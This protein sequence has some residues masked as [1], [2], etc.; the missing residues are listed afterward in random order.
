[1]PALY[2]Q[3]KQLRKELRS[4]PAPMP[5]TYIDDVSFCCFCKALNH[6]PAQ[7]YAVILLLCPTP[8][9]T[10]EA[11]LPSIWGRPQ[12]QHQ[13]TYCNRSLSNGCSSLTN[14]VL[15]INT[16]NWLIFSR[17]LNQ[18]PK[19]SCAN[20]PA[21]LLP[22]KNQ[23]KRVWVRW[24]SHVLVLQLIISCRMWRKVTLPLYPLRRG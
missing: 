3:P 1:M 19:Q 12:S 17:E 8:N 5:T 13:N 14:K 21:T 20:K 6:L 2:K 7:C 15:M 10:G 23:T 22:T 24:T 11:N 18:L 9:E 4:L 16:S